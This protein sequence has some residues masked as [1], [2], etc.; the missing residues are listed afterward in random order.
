[1][2]WLLSYIKEYSNKSGLKE[3]NPGAQL[4]LPM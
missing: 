3:Y 2:Y 4:P 1:M